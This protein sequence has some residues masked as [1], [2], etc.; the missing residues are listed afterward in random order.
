MQALNAA[1]DLINEYQGWAVD[2]L[3]TLRQQFL[4]I[5]ASRDVD[6]KEI[7]EMFDIAHEIRGQGGS[8]GFALISAI[9]DSLCKFIEG[10]QQLSDP[11]L[12]VIKVHIMAMKAV[13]HQQ[14]K[15]RQ[16]DLAEQLT[17]LLQ[18]LRNKV[19]LNASFSS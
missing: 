13:F 7:A 2:D 4:K 5:S 8:F 11:E 18:A 6:K 19:N 1:D 3:E 10:R 14:L 15:G 16:K 9:A 17:E 12:E